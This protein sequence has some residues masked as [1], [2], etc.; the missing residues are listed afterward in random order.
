MPPNTPKANDITQDMDVVLGPL[1]TQAPPIQREAAPDAKDVQSFYGS[2]PDDTQR[3][4]I[5]LE[6]NPEIPPTGL[7]LGHN[8]VGYL[9]MPGEPVRV[10]KFLLNVLNDAIMDVPTMDPQTNQVVG[11]R[12]RMRFPYRMAA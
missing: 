5:V 10:P 9:I 7:Y 12:R 8:G 4:T 11:Y 6:E 3:V 1:P 2:A